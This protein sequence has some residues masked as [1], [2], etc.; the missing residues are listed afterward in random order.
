MSKYSIKDLALLSGIKAH[1]IRIW[2][3][4]YD[5]LTPLRTNS[6][7]RSYH[8]DDLKYLIR[9]AG[10]NLAGKR[11]SALAEKTREEIADGFTMLRLES[12]S[13]EIHVQSLLIDMLDLDEIG[14]RKN[15]KSIQSKIGFD[16]TCTKVCFRLIEKCNL[17][18]TKRKMPSSYEH[19]AHALI[20]NYI[21]TQLESST[22]KPNPNA[23]TFVLFL[24]ENYFHESALHYSTYKLKQ[25]G[26]RVIYLGL[27][28]SPDNILELNADL[29]IDYLLTTTHNSLTDR[30][31]KKRFKKITEALNKGTVLVVNSL[32]AES[33]IEGNKKGTSKALTSDE[34]LL[35]FL[36]TDFGSQSDRQVA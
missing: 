8:L 2:E 26:H 9:I 29:K 17:V 20:R 1:T 25:S 19:F 12:M 33:L 7:F 5:L 6:N 31:I 14:F 4:R 35:E 23:K 10:L 3:Q 24:L 11:I 36:N 18:L 22:F 34:A 28:V 15:L 32:N 16:D 21:I 30:K 13:P 27:G